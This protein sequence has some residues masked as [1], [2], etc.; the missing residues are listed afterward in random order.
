MQSY[1][2]S[3]IMSRMSNYT[4]FGTC[5]RDKLKKISTNKG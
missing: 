2:N 5:V 4:F 3:T 1:D